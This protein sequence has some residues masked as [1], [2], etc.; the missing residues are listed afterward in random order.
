MDELPEMVRLPA[1]ELFKFAF[2]LLTN[3]EIRDKQFKIIFDSILDKVCPFCGIELFDAPTAPRE[4]LDHYLMINKYVFAGA[5]L[6]NLVPI[7]DKCN[8]GY[9][10]TKDIIY[11]NNGTRRRAFYPYN[12]VNVSVILNNSEIFANGNLHNWEVEF[13]INC[14]EIETWNDVFDIRNR[15]KR[16]ILDVRFKSWIRIFRDWLQNSNLEGDLVKE[17]LI[18]KLAE[19]ILVLSDLKL[20]GVDS[21][22]LPLFKMLKY[23]C[24]SENQKVILFLLDTILL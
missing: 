21:L 14:E 9:K 10:K 18:E 13:D 15:Y 16:D 12:P 7:G 1:S 5:N 22:R 24:E 11:R 17:L 20:N 3:L 4:D 6:S 8:Q 19:Y 23:Q 2:N